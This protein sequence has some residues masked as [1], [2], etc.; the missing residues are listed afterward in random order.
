LSQVLEYAIFR[1][2]RLARKLHLGRLIKFGSSTQSFLDYFKGFDE[3]EAVKGIFG[4]ETEKV[5]QNLKV[6]FTWF[7]G[8]MFVDSSDGHLVVNSS[9]LRTGDKTDI[10]LDLVHELCHVK[11]FMDGRELFDPRYSYVDRPTEIEA[12]AYTVKEARRLGLSDER[13]CLYLQTEW[14]T[15]ED[16]ERLAVSLHVVL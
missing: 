14:L 2:F 16:L 6:E 15:K 10:Y 5:L 7:G 3:L 9:Y 12:Y 1:G 8:Y 13:I 4:N 11:Q